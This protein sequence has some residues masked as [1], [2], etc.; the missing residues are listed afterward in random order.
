M[1]VGE[2]KLVTY[3]IVACIV[4]IIGFVAPSGSYVRDVVLCIPSYF[5]VLFG[6]YAFVRI[7]YKLSNIDS[8]DEEL[9]FLNKGCTRAKE[10]YKG[11][12]LKLN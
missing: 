7:G 6:S 1:S 11:K 2:R 10:F 4:L 12:G 5:A 3:T 9:D 8:H